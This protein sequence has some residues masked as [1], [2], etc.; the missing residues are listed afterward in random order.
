M[1]T[2]KEL[3]CILKT[4]D[5]KRPSVE[6]MLDDRGHEYIEL[7]LPHDW[8]R[9]VGFTREGYAKP[10]DVQPGDRM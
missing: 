4:L 7:T 8:P 2:T 1:I 3:I 10:S 9:L 6:V 5:S